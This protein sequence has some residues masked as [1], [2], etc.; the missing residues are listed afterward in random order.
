MIVLKIA[1]AQKS[2]NKKSRAYQPKVGLVGE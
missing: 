1:S 2:F